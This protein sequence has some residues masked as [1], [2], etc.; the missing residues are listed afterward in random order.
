MGEL[1]LIETTTCVNNVWFSCFKMIILA[2]IEIDEFTY[3][4]TFIIYHENMWINL[5]QPNE[6]EI[7]ENTFYLKIV[8]KVYTTSKHGCFLLHNRINL[9]LMSF[10]IVYAMC[11]HI[12]LIMDAMLCSNIFN[13]KNDLF[14]DLNIGKWPFLTIF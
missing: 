10:L 6:L 7:Q 9:S 13:R 2:S 11:N 8:T 1:T 3:I 12:G 14:N 4:T 5:E